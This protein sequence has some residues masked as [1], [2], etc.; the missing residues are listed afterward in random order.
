M[1]QCIGGFKNSK[2]FKSLMPFFHHNTTGWFLQNL[3]QT[4][5]TIHLCKF[6][7]KFNLS[8]IAN[9]IS[10]CMDGSSTHKHVPSVGTKVPSHTGCRWVGTSNSLEWTCYLAHTI[11]IL[12]YS[13]LAAYPKFWNRLNHTIVTQNWKLSVFQ[14]NHKFFK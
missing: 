4:S 5:E 6:H 14:A 7:I 10:I 9:F 3:L 13:N 1:F 12:P 2:P 11:I 8:I